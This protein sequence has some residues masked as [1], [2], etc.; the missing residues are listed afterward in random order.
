MLHNRNLA[1]DI[2]RYY[3]TRED[4]T[5]QKEEVIAEKKQRCTMKIRCN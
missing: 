5:S 4:S 3:Q 1:V 2:I